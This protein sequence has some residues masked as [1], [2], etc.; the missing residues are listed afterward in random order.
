MSGNTGESARGRRGRRS[1]DDAPVNVRLSRAALELFSQKGFHATG[2]REIGAHA[3]VSTSMLYHY[4]SSKDE[5][6]TD[7]V[8]EGLSRHGQALEDACGIVDR[9]EEKLAALIGV[10]IIIPVKHPQMGQLLQQELHARDWSDHPAISRQRAR[11]NRLWTDVLTRGRS[12]GVFTFESVSLARI[13]LMRSTTLV[14]QWYQADGALGLDTVAA[15]FADL[16]L[17]TVRAHRDGRPLRFGDLDGPS[18]ARLVEVV[19]NAHRDVWW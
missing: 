8:L 17:G 6:L 18:V 15:Q 10:H 2:I 14:T 4:L 9:P 13:A 5:A 7:L 11:T 3:G 12:E 19:E 1:A 16:A